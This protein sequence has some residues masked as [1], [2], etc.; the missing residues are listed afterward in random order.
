[1]IT[2]SNVRTIEGFVPIWQSTQDQQR[3]TDEII[4]VFKETHRLVDEWP[5]YSDREG[6]FIKLRNEGQERP[7]RVYIKDIICKKGYPE[8]AE[9]DVLTQLE[10]WIL[11]TDEG[12]VIWVSPPYPG[13]YPCTKIIIHQIAYEPKTLEKVILNSAIVFDASEKDTLG[14]LRRLFPQTED[15]SGLEELRSVLILPESDFD[16]DLLLQEISYLDENVLRAE[17]QISHDDL[18]A[19]ANYISSLI[20]SGA[21]PRL[22]AYEMQRLGLLGKFSISCPSLG[23]S[24]PF[25]EVIGGGFSAEDQY[26]SLQFTCPRCRGVNTRPYGNLISNCQHCGA[27]VKC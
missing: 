22:V 17:Q 4:S 15:I 14:L 16:P 26:G 6:I 24:L 23:T 25:S 3:T 2:E 18:M 21:N 20:S 27:D 19:R 12:W 10:R 9:A 13:K 5:Y 7:D 8:R 1:M 11:E